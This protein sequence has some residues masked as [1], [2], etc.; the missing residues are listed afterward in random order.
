MIRSIKNLLAALILLSLVL[1]PM[2]LVHAS[3]GVPGSAEFGFGSDIYPDEPY[4]D[5]ALQMA[6]ELDLDW[7]QVHITWSSIQPEAGQPLRMERID[8]IMAFAAQRGIAV[9]FSLTGTP[10]WARTG[11]GPDTALTAQMVTALAM[12]Y[13]GTLQAVELFPG[14]NTLSGWG[15]RPDPQA[16]TNLYRIC[17]DRLQ[18]SG[19]SILLV[20][21][22][23]R[24]ADLVQGDMHDLTYLDGLY[25]AGAASAMPVISLRFENVTGAP[26]VFPDSQNPGVLRHYEEIRQVMTRNDHH[27]GLIWITHLGSLSGKISA[28]DSAYLDMNMQSNWM[29]LAY[30]QLR[31]QLYIGVTFGQSINPGQGGSDAGSFS[32]IEPSG[33]THPFYSVLREMISL[34]NT[35]SVSL[36]PGKSKEG[37]LAKMRP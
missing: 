5:Q 22:G 14:A 8:P 33:G 16:Y 17:A 15:A 1:N 28:T 3:R 21:A 13:P 31:T 18:Q 11:T 30:R 20:A 36:L 34:N 29:A 24:P 7:I 2:D 23:L 9:M 4:V 35:G 32:L 10:T 19:I 26:S 12:A 27:S 37:N 25:K 6:G